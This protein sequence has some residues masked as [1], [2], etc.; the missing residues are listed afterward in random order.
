M[1]RIC[2]EHRETVD[3]LVSGCPGLCQN[4]VRTKTQGSSIPPQGN[5]QALRHQSAR[6]IL[7]TW[8]IDSNWKQPSDFTLGHASPDRQRD[9]GKQARHSNER[10]GEEN[11]PAHWYVY[12]KWKKKHLSKI[13]TLEKLPK[14]KD[15]ETEIEK[16]RKPKTRTVPVVIGVLRLV[17]KGTGNYISKIPGNIRITEPQKIVLLGTVHI[18]R[19][20]LSIR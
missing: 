11:L 7:Q 3:H 18:L 19:R 16:T 2:N 9:Q 20:S 1:R 13:K 14:C 17:K 8:A 10:Q 6:Q 15:L 12:P 4:R 5:L